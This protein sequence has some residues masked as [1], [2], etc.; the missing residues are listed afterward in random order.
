MTANPGLVILVEE[1]EEEDA[2]DDAS[3]SERLW[4]SSAR[5]A[6]AMALPSMTLPRVSAAADAATGG[7]AAGWEDDMANMVMLQVRDDV[8]EFGLEGWIEWRCRCWR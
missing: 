8:D 6:S 2:D 5:M 7:S 3:D 4:A 1:E